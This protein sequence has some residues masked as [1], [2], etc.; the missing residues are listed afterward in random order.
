[1]TM[2][3]IKDLTATLVKMVRP[4]ETETHILD[5]QRKGLLSTRIRQGNSG[6][7][8]AIDILAVDNSRLRFGALVSRPPRSLSDC[9]SLC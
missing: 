3:I 5:L 2:T 6:S 1:M 7:A 8:D 9:I 4:V